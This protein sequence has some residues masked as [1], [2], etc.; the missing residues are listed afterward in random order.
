MYTKL[1]ERLVTKFSIKVTDLIKYLEISKATIYNYRNL[2]NFEDIPKDKQYKIFYLFG[3]ETEE[4]LALVLDESDPDI[5][6]GYL[7]RISSILNESA[8]SKKEGL[9]SI[10]EL[11]AKNQTL[12]QENASLKR[13]SLELAKFKEMDEFTRTVLFDKL[14]A[15]TEGATTAEMKEFMDYLD[16]FEKYRSVT[17]KG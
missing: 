7:A 3:K 4:E 17:K 9:S 13:Q 12:M 2:E 14:A 1:F 8:K 6:A 5:L 10:E 15:I 11:T 16:I